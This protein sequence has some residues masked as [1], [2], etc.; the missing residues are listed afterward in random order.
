MNIYLLIH[1]RELDRR[2]NTGVL[3]TEVMGEN[4]QLFVWDRVAPDAKLLEKLKQESVALVYPREN[5]GSLAADEKTFDSFI[6]IDAT[7]Q[8]AQKM[9]N[10][11]QYLQNLP[12]VNLSRE[13]PSV[14]ILRRN[15]K[16]AGLCTAE[17]A[18]ELLKTSGNLKQ[19]N[20]MEERLKHF[21][22]DIHLQGRYT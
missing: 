3:V 17:C 2:T 7:W 10:H 16:E 12:K 21:I 13:K 4:C 19:G 1:Q 11:S 22:A 20:I 9:Y 5:G 18:A 15:Q 8:E 6:I 14:Y